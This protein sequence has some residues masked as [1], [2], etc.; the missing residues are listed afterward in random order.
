[1]SLKKIIIILLTFAGFLLWG[2]DNKNVLSENSNKA[3][4]NSEDI[5]SAGENNPDKDFNHAGTNYTIETFGGVPRIAS[6]G[7]PVRGRLFYGAFPGAKHAVVKDKK[8]ISL[9]K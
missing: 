6:D 9:L 8:R 4:N 2:C 3:S 7:Y 1:M 5:K